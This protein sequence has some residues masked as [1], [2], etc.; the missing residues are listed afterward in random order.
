MGK[1]KK[2]SYVQGA[3]ILSVA[4]MISKI[5]GALFKIPLQMM[6]QVAFGY[7]NTAYEIY[8]PISTIAMAGLP[9]AVSR[10]VSESITLKRYRDVRM[11]YRVAVKTFLITGSVGA[12]LMFVVSFFYT[13]MINAPGALYS[14]LVMS[15]TIFFC[16][17]VSA[18]R[19]LYEGTRNMVPTAT[20]QVIEAVGKLVLGL[21]FAYGALLYGRWQF[22]QGK[23]VFGTMATDAANADVLSYPFVAA[24]AMLGVTLGSFFALIYMM[25]RH[26]RHGTGLQVSREE[27]AAAPRPRSSRAIFRALMAIAIPVA[28]GS[29]ATQVTNL[30]DAVSCSGA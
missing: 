2:Q 10:M 5:V 7:F 1:Q 18:H 15:P 23:P 4:V 12:L 9:I 24:G 22:S 8:V 25:I 17:L 26:R 16:C 3:L 13:R 6:S 14:M 28:L 21:T 30:I 20:S 29:L 11:V 27:Y 19:G